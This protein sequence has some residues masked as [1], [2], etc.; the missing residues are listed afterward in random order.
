METDAFS[1]P[2]SHDEKPGFMVGL[3]VAQR[4][5]VQHHAEKGT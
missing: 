5:N 2:K 1:L 3:S 4:N